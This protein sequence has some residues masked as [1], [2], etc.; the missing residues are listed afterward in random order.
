MVNIGFC[1]ERGSRRGKIEHC[2]EIHRGG[3]GMIRCPLEDMVF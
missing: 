1:G 2:G 3:I